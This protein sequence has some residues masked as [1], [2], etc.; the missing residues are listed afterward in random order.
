[1]CSNIWKVIAFGMDISLG[2]MA[3]STIH[4]SSFGGGLHDMMAV[5]KSTQ[6]D[7]SFDGIHFRVIQFRYLYVHILGLSCC[8]VG[9]G[10]YHII[11]I[12]PEV[13][14]TFFIPNTLP[15]KN[16]MS[17]SLSSVLLFM[18]ANCPTCTSLNRS[19]SGNGSSRSI[20]SEGETSL[21]LGRCFLVGF[22]V[23]FCGFPRLG[24]K[25]PLCSIGG[26]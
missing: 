13:S 21:V 26:R 14:E 5:S 24:P 16:G 2:T 3:F 8:E 10:Q 15:R 11:L 25:Y 17:D 6:F 9:F 19:N 18:V 22:E 20:F 12:D 1:M 23:V 4:V 7:G